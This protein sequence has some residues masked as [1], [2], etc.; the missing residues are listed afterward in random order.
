MNSATIKYLLSQ[1][2]LYGLLARCFR[3]PE[4]GWWDTIVN[5][6]REIP[7]EWQGNV[8]RL[9]TQGPPPPDVYMALFGTAGACHDCETAFLTGLP[10]EG[11]LADVAG[12]YQAFSFPIASRKGNPPDHI[13]TQL[14]FISFMFAKEAKAIFQ[15]DKEARKICLTAREKFVREHLSQWVPLFANSL[16][17]HATNAFYTQAA[18]LLTEAVKEENT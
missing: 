9:L 5:L 18:T 12:F 1:S 8:Q 16:A 2:A 11:T 13:A 3:P 6:S 17:E 4:N 14:E 7:K 15:E 10:T